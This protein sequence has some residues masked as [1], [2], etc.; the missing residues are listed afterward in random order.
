MPFFQVFFLWKITKFH[1]SSGFPEVLR[2]FKAFQ[3]KW[4][5]CIRNHSCWKYSCATNNQTERTWAI[6]GPRVEAGVESLCGAIRTGRTTFVPPMVSG[7]VSVPTGFERV[8]ATLVAFVTPGAG[9]RGGGC[10]VTVCKQNEFF[11]LWRKKKQQKS[12]E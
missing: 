9:R 2:L 8:G 10:R 11:R 3:V 5:T 1:N 4:E 7:R 12:F 6:C